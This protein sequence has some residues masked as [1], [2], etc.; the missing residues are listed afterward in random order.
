[1]W[2]PVMM[3]F[4][5]ALLR[6]LFHHLGESKQIAVPTAN[7]KWLTATANRLMLN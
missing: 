1:M 3:R 6:K 4:D 7:P 2:L 5:G